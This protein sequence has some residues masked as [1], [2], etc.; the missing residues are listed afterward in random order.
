MSAR[1]CG[2]R[3]SGGV[4]AEC[5]VGGGGRPFL[6]FMFCP[7]RVVAPEIGLSPQG[8]VI[9]EDADGRQLMMDWVGEKYYPNCLD[10]V[11]E[12]G[13]MGLSWRISPQ[14]AKKLRAGAFGVPVHPRGF[15]LNWKEMRGRWVD[16]CPKAHGNPRR[17]DVPEGADY[18]QLWYD[19]LYP[20]LKEPYE[21]GMCAGYHWQNVYTGITV[22][23]DNEFTSGR[24]IVPV[25]REMPG[26]TYTAY[27][28]T[29]FK[30]QYEPAAIG[31]WPIHCLA[32]IDGGEKTQQNI[33]FLQDAG[34]PVRLAQE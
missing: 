15:I 28:T 14:N 26:F 9:W 6:D 2:V 27:M 7:P 21:H 24:H 29:G 3:V 20:L 16:R 19:D 32:V 11:L 4:Y 31:A 33:D 17:H 12:G 30:P 25:E 22:L 13:R 34:L 18:E 23:E 8:Q 1:G 5:N 10:Y